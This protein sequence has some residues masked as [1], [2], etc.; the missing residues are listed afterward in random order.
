MKVSDSEKRVDTADSCQ[1]NAA[2]R[3]RRNSVG[4]IFSPHDLSGAQARRAFG[5]TLPADA[6]RY[7]P[8]PARSEKNGKVLQ[9]VFSALAL[10]TRDTDVTGWYQDHSVVG[11]MFTEIAVD[12]KK[13]IL[14]HHAAAGQQRVARLPD[15]RTVQPDQYFLPSVSRG[16]GRG[17]RATPS[18]R[19]PRSIRICGRR[20]AAKECRAGSS[21]ALDLTGASP[22][23]LVFS[24]LFLL[25]AVAVK[26]SSKGPI[27][28]RQQRI[29]QL[30]SASPFSSSV[31]CM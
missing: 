7:R 31:P 28:F 3:E 16:L 25:I 27:L 10:S 14:A 29:G 22:R 26:F 21:A 12:L 5:Q 9:N 1:G 11:V 15:A 8:R 4:G 6:A 17:R 2:R 20:T 23:L 18:R 24:P 30:G 19:I 13:S